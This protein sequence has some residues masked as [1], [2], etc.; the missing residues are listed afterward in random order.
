MGNFYTGLGNEGV[1][2]ETTDSSE[3]SNSVTDR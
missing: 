2:K 3:V 1:N